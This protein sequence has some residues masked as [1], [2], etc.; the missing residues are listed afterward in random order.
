MANA[1]KTKTDEQ[2]AAPAFIVAAGQV[3]AGPRG[4]R[5]VK[6]IGDPY[7]PASD[8]ERDQLLAA[9]VIVSAEDFAKK[10]GG[11]PIAAA[12]QAA[13]ARAA[14]AEAELAKLKAAGQPQQ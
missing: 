4:R 1:Q 6:N 10:A 13:E 11:A 9:G 12:L 5:V 2:G 14:A 3:V 7:A 8:E